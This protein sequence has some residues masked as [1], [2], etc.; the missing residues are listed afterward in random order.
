[1]RTKAATARTFTAI[2]R[3]GGNV[4]ITDLGRRL[5]DSQRRDEARVDAFLRVPL[6]SEIFTKFEGAQLPPDN[7]LEL[8]MARLGVSEKQTE[9]ARQA[10][11]RSAAH[12]GFF[13]QGKDRLIRPIGSPQKPKPPEP[14]KD[15]VE[16]Q[17]GTSAVPL[18]ELWLTLLN[19]GS[20]WSAETTHEFV[21]HARRLRELLAKSG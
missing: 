6:F 4:A 19:E 9:R 7:A 16:S 15:Q 10:F 2:S 3:G 8:E 12:A 5:I 14:R 21:E 17:P 20:S 13:R 18:A 11:Q 1:M